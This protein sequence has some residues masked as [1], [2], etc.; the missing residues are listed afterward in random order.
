MTGNINYQVN[1][2]WNQLDGIKTSKKDARKLTANKGANGHRVSEMVHGT[3]YKK[4][5]IQIA[6][7]L[8]NFAKENFG[9]K[10]MQR[11]NNDIV[12]KFI[13]NKIEDGVTQK[14]LKAY[15]TKLEKVHI[16]L[17]KIPQQIKAHEKLFDREIFKELR[18]DIN[19]YAIKT[20]HVNRAYINPQVI[21]NGMKGANNIAA[22]LQLN[23]GLRVSEA[24]QISAEQ[25]MSNNRII[26]NGK[27]G[28]TRI[29]TV[30]NKLLNELKMHMKS[31]GN[32]SIS[33]S[34]YEQN[35]HES[36][37]KNGEKYNGTH[38]LRYNYAQAKYAEYMKTMPHQNAMQKVSYD[39][40]HKRAE[41]TKN[42]L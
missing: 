10:D 41:I 23:H 39:L 2:I 14:S 5:V 9:I 27:G 35:L 40:G 17:S 16:G 6:R 25:L 38:G 31:S 28:F 19:K 32:F 11:I 4:D 26:I 12:H 15:V 34:K 3:K 18:T 24:T 13:H 22:Q 42:Y 8:G 21:V 7:E 20:G 1:Q 33:Y 30:E 37:Y 36:V 29:I